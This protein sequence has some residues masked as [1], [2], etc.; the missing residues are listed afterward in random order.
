MRATP[1][2]AERV[3][4]I[5]ESL[6][7]EKLDGW[8]FY[9][10]RGSDPLALRILKLDQHAVGS[11]RWFFYVPATGECV[12]IV[13]RIEAAKLDSLSGQRR[14][15]S[16]WKEQ[17]ELLKSV[18]TSAKNKPRIAMQYSPMNDIPY[19]AKVDAGTVELIRSFGVDVVS[20][21]ELVQ[22]FEAVWS[23]EQLQMH[24]EASDKMHRI[25]F[26]AFGE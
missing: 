5:Q 22:Q 23:P 15:Y 26:D 1:S 17:H 16:S 18:L 11:R 25:F 24:I 4:E 13:H 21:A 7:T 19:M 20:S 2:P 9:D 6:Q 3:S 8:L 14:E 12:K 10:F